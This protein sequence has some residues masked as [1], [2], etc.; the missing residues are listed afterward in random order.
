MP[1]LILIGMMGSGKSTV[2][3]ILADTTGVPFA[4]SDAVLEVRMGR[5]ISQ[6]FQLYG[7]EAFR[8]HETAVLKSFDPDPGILA[9]GGGIVM[10]E[11]NWAEFARLGQTIFL[12]VDEEVLVRRLEA[13]NRKRPLL[14]FE[15][16]QDRFREL[17]KR[18]RPLYERADYRVEIGDE[19]F[20]DVVEKILNMEVKG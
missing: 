8:A 15:D 14:A 17:M 16:W 7:E 9:T 19:A 3:R 10:R 18:R 6:M 2:G 4:D 13:S 20:E 11:E 1:H 5:T 12:D